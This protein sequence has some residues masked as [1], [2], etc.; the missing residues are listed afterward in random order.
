MAEEIK[1][2]GSTE[3]RIS[4]AVSDLAIIQCDGLSTEQEQEIRASGYDLDQILADGGIAAEGLHDAVFLTE[5]IARTTLGTNYERIIASSEH[6]IDTIRLLRPSRVIDLGGGC[7][8]TCFDAARNRS[9]CHFVI[10][11]RSRNALKLG[12]RWA[13][14]LHLTNVSFKRLDFTEAHVESVLGSDNDL[15]VFEYVFNH[16]L[17][18]ETDMIA[19]LSPGMNTAARLLN[20][21]G[22]LCVRFGKF[23]EPGLTGLVRAAHRASF[24]VYSISAGAT[25]CSFIF[26]REPGHDSEDAEVFHAID[27]VGCQFRA[28]DP[29]D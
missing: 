7:G 28:L 22:K 17:E 16:S 2:S 27:E 14:F 8:V 13:Q 12:Q 5:Q 29:G 10:C 24:S 26:T 20:S 3:R 6:Y 15:A 18:Y 19:Q 25:G 4:T 23:S 1:N 11:D 9:D 21:R